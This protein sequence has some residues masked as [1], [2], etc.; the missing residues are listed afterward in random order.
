MQSG[1][2]TPEDLPRKYANEIHANEIVLLAYYI[3]AVN[4]ET[5][6]HEITG[7]DYKAFEGICL[8]DTFE[9]QEGDDLL[10][11]I[12]PDNSGRRTRQKETDIRVIVENPPWSA[13]QRSAND[14]AANQEYPGVDG[15]IEESYAR[16]SRAQLKRFLH[17][18]YIRAIRWASDR[19]GTSGVIGLVTGSAWLERTFADGMRKCLAEEFSS[20]YVFHLRGDI[21][22]NML[23]GGKAGEGEN[24][25]VQGSMT[26]CAITIFVKNPD[27]KEHGR[28]LFR[29]IGDDLDRE[30]KLK[31]VRQFGSIRGIAQSGGWAWIRPDAK[32]D[33]LGQG[34]MEFVR[35]TMIGSK[36]EV[37]QAKTRFFGNYSHGVATNRDTWCYNFSS[38]ALEANIRSMICFYNSELERFE[39]KQPDGSKADINLF[40]NNDPGKISWSSS[41]LSHLKRKMPINFDESR[42]VPSIY[43]PF[44]RKWLYF[45]SSVNDRT[46]QMPQIFPH[47]DAE[48]R[49]I[50]VTGVGARAGFSVLMV[51]AIPNLHTMDTG[52][53][54]PFYLY[55]KRNSDDSLFGQPADATDA[56][57]YTRR[58]AITDNVLAKFRAAYDDTVSKRDIFH[59]IY[60]LLHIP[61][62]RHRFA[63]NLSKELPRIPLAADPDHF[64]AL[65]A[66]GRELGDLHVGFDRVDPWPLEFTNGDWDAPAGTDPATYFRVQKMKLGGT[67]KESDLTTI[68]YNSNITVTSIPAAW[69]YEV[70]GKPALKWVME[71][72]AVSTDRDSGIVNDANHYATETIGD[73]SYPLKLLACV[74]RVSME[75]N[76]IVEELPEPKWIE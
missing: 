20:L 75:T 7:G 25:F 54:F 26:G 19:I 35:F 36:K 49:L 39:S 38:S 32:Y 53:C 13:G 70:N 23:S 52:Q 31:A 28:I 51:D 33:W 10:A 6:Y 46:G 1:L 21:R 37:D 14:N 61:A 48:N 2:I 47:R 72:Q 43:R 56:H 40:V 76:R 60:G 57:G 17:D 8:A 59:Y 55:D 66:A 30:A 73:P 34:N 15:R 65:V 68:I 9:M 24:I 16:Y 41:L 42:I 74:I 44:T 45:S 62:Y 69:D 67:R 58:D 63:N 27:A 11:Q 3:A 50:C 64:A 4:I 18:S 71:R 22:K 29:D 12:M 5:A